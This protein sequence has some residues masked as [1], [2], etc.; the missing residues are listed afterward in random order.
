MTDKNLI[1]VGG[2]GHC[3]S[4]IDV[5]EGAGYSVKGILDL[6]ENIGKRVLN[7]TIDGTDEYIS[8]FVKNHFFVV[9]VGQIENPTIRIKLHEKIKAAGGQLATI[10]ATTAHV[11]KYALIGE[12]SVV[13]HY[14]VVNA[15]A[16][17]GKG[18]IINT[19]ANIEHDVEIGDFC[20]ISTG[21]MVNGN[22]KVGGGSFIGSQAVLANG[23]EIADGCIIS[24]GSMVRK[25]IVEKGV[26]AG[27]PAELKKRL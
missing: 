6:A 18:C 17:V 20:H 9:T 16:V 10:I 1:L 27:N 3:K 24:A 23:L 19:F 14:A 22:C 15:D 26:Y 4:V 13:M 8:K 12:G 25:S 11:S 21:V 5:A 7:Y 2:G